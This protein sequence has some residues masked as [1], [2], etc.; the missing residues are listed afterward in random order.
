MAAVVMRPGVVV[1]TVFRLM[2][3]VA[4]VVSGKDPLPICSLSSCVAFVISVATVKNS[5]VQGTKAVMRE[6]EARHSVLMTSP[7][8]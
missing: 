2:R 5:A 3:A 6:P 8:D 7:I 1:A 4:D